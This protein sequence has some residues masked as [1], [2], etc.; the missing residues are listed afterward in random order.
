MFTKYPDLAVFVV[1]ALGRPVVV[2]LAL[3]ATACGP[4][5]PPK[6]SAPAAG[7]WREFEGSWN[8]AGSRRTISLGADRR[9]SIIDLRGSMLLAGSGRPG[10]GFRSDIIALVDSGTGLIGRGVWTDEKGD[11]V[12]SELKG[13]DTAA[14]NYIAGTILGGTGRYAGITGSY[15]FSWQFV[16]ETEDGSIQGNAVGLKGRFRTGQPSAGEAKP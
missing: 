15:E 16:I 3:A 8:A 4:S 1:R 2:A 12:F 9:A 10:I 14:K 7:E 5:E 11:Q 13:E 6:S